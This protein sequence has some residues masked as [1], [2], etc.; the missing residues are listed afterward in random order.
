MATFTS[1]HVDDA[2]YAK[3]YAAE[4]AGRQPGDHFQAIG[5]ANG[6]LPNAE[7]DP[8]LEQFKDVAGNAD[9]PLQQRYNALCREMI[10]HFP[11]PAYDGYF[12]TFLETHKPPEPGAK[13]QFDQA[14]IGDPESAGRMGYLYGGAR[15]D[16]RQP[17]CQAFLDRVENGEDP[18]VQARLPHGFWDGIARVFILEHILAE[19]FPGRGLGDEAR[20]RLA[21]RLARHLRPND[22]QSILFTENFLHEVRTLAAGSAPERPPA[23]AFKSFPDGGTGLFGRSEVHPPRAPFV[24]KA[25]EWL[26]PGQRE[27]GDA[28][29]MKRVVMSG[30]FQ[31]FMDRIRHRPVVLVA[32]QFLSDFGERFDLPAFV[33]VEVPPREAH[34]V[35]DDIWERCRQALSPIV[36][37]A[38]PDAPP[39]VLTRCGGS[40]AFHLINRLAREFPQTSFVDL[41]QSAD[42]WFLDRDGF[43]RKGGLPW[44]PNFRKQIEINNLAEFYRSKCGIADF[45]AFHIERHGE[46]KPAQ[47]W[48]PSSRFLQYAQLAAARGL[49]DV[50]DLF[51]ERALSQT[52][53]DPALLRFID[54]RKAKQDRTV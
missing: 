40:F 22:P 41:G 21:I 8:T 24:F 2:F 52:P 43:V 30:M 39:I 5:L 1:P 34:L 12:W 50:A 36:S 15:H 37:A 13:A 42:L 19:Q 27:F 25:V 48:S 46:A 31:P 38:S 33:F 17:S 10:R 32:N 6:L 51:V 29:L 44:S 7:L 23:L 47:R 11:N 35:R 9:R 49:D 45:A 3:T 20:L 54:Q 26:K 53:D 18:V 4:L 28:M 14:L 16:I